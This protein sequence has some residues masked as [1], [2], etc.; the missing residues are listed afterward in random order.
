MHLYREDTF[1]S[2]HGTCFLQVICLGIS[3]LASTPFFVLTTYAV[4]PV[5]LP[6]VYLPLYIESHQRASSLSHL[7]NQAYM[8][9]FQAI[10]FS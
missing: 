5:F 1:F 9:W 4:S 7:L 2:L 10:R 6:P 3:N 8:A